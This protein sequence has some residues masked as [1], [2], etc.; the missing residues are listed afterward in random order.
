MPKF[1]KR[2]AKKV[3]GA[4]K[5]RYFKGKGYR[6]PKLAQ[7]AKDVMYLKGVLNPEKKNFV[8]STAGTAIPVG[9]VSGPASNG[10]YSFDMTPTPAQGTTSITRNGNS[11]KLHSSYIRFQFS[12]MPSTTNPI[13]VKIM[14]ILVKGQ[15]LA[16]SGYA[17]TAAVWLNPN[18]FIT[19]GTIYDY[20]SDMNPDYFGTIKVLRTKTLRVA[21]DQFSGSNQIVNVNMPMKYFRGKGHHVRFVADGS[22]SLADGQLICLITCDNGNISGTNASTLS[23][24][25]LQSSAV[26]TGLYMSYVIEHYYYDN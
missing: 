16:S 22:T 10:G 6:N 23:G 8:L 2:V 17:N 14:I 19:G 20:N 12:Q 9:Q 18:P 21:Q 1:I 13:K 15:P 3:G 4:V 24:A 5:R 25:P 7:M 26:T 11:I